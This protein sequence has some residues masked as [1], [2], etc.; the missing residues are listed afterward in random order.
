[1]NNRREFGGGLV[2]MGM[3]VR[4]IP[5]NDLEERSWLWCLD[6]LSCVGGSMPVGASHKYGRTKDKTYQ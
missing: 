6:V 2:G 1:M 3:A 4:S 5:R